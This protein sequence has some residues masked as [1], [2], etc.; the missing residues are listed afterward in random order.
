MNSPADYYGLFDASPEAE[1]AEI[2]SAYRSAFIGAV[3]LLVLLP[4]AA[5]VITKAK[6]DF[7][8]NLAA[9][10]GTL[11]SWVAHKESDRKTFL[12]GDYALTLSSREKQSGERVAVLNVKASSGEEITVHGQLGYPIPSADFGVGRLDPHNQASQVIFTTYSG[13]THCCTKIT[14]LE[15][16]R[17]RWHK[18]DLGTWDGDPLAE[19][20]KDMD[21]DGAPEIILKDDRFDYAFAPYTETYKPPRIFAV[22]KGRAIDLSNSERF[23]KICEA[24]MEEAHS[25]CL[26]HKNAACA[27]FVADASRLGRRAW[28]WNIMKANYRRS[29]DWDFPTKC[30]VPLVKDVCPAGRTEQFREFPDALD[31]F[32]ADKGYVNR[33]AAAEDTHR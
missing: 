29:K 9:P 33:R 6:I 27:A 24:D 1:D 21:G 17:G 3:I 26:D 14:V 2:R 16:M 15:L 19:F 10:E 12:I 18:I 22:R 7:T 28:A 30:T 25:G 13:G 20:P 32:L 23:D 8:E 4:L 31:W 11:M 5:T